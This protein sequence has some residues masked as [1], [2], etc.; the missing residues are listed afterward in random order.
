MACSDSSGIYVSN[1]NDYEVNIYMITTANYSTI[2]NT[3]VDT[4]VSPPW[5]VLGQ[6]FDARGWNVIVGFKKGDPIC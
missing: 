3:M 4:A 1:N 6:A 2:I 5:I